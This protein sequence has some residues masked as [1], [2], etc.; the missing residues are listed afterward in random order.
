MPHLGRGYISDCGCRLDEGKVVLTGQGKGLL[1]TAFS[2]IHPENTLIGGAARCLE[3]LLS[4]AKNK[5]RIRRSL[6][7]YGCKSLGQGLLL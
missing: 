5:T 1:V 3:V 2:T 7:I 6:M 4:E